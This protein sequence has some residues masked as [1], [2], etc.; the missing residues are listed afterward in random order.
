MSFYMAQE[1]N[2]LFIMVPEDTFPR[3]LLL[4]VFGEQ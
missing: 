2:P 3:I 1:T 4:E